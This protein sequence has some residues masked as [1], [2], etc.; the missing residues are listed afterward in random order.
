LILPQVFIPCIFSYLL[1]YTCPLRLTK[2]IAAATPNIANIN[3]KQGVGV[4]V[5]GEGEGI[6]IAWLKTQEVRGGFFKLFYKLLPPFL[7]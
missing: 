4:G 5:T 3:S 7:V 1:P 2:H 6:R